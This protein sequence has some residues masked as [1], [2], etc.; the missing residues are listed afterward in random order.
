MKYNHFVMGKI[1]VQI[2]IGIYKQKITI[3]YSKFD[4]R[5]HSLQIYN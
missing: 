4:I 2:Q 5:H 3:S 1:A